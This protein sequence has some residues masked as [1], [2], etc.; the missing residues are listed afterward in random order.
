MVIRT[1]MGW[2]AGEDFGPASLVDVSRQTLCR[3]EVL[4]ATSLA[5]HAERFHTEKAFQGMGITIIR[6]LQD[7]TNSDVWR[8]NKLMAFMRHTIALNDILSNDST[9]KALLNEDSHADHWSKP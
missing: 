1:N 9:M 6:T 7:A 8:K 4:A 5:T 3:S 2:I